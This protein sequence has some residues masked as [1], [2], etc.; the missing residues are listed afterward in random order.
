LNRRTIL[1][2]SGVLLVQSVLVASVFTPQP[3]SGG[4]NAGYISLAHSLL[5]RGAYLEL[6]DPDEPPHTK[7]PPVFAA[8]L[9]LAVLV[10]AKSWA[11]LKL[12]PAFSTVL[13]VAFSF[14]WAR[15]RHGPAL[16]VAVAVLVEISSS[17][18]YYSQWI[19]SD[20]AF[21]AVTVAALWF[22]HR[23]SP[24]SLGGEEREGRTSYLLMGM[25]LVVLAYFTR[26]AGLPLAVATILWLAIGKRWKLLAGFA[27]GFGVP[28]ALWW[29]RG[30]VL[31]GSEYVSEFWLIDPY[32]PHLGS[33]GFAELLDR[34]A[35]N[36][37]AYVTRIIPGGVVGDRVPALPPLGL[38][39]A[40][41]TLVGWLRVLRKE[42]GVAELF[43]PLYAGLILLWPQAWS[44]DR[45][46]LP[47]LPLIFFYSGTALIWLLSAVPER[48]RRV[49]L[50]VL[51]L[52]LVVPAGLFWSDLAR[53]A[54]SCRQSTRAGNAMECLS[55]AQAEYLA[56][57]EWSGENLP[58]GATVTTRKPRFFFLMSGK[59]SL[60]IP[61][62]R[63]P[64]ALLDR[65]RTRGSRYVSVDFLDGLSGYYLYPVL[66][67]NLS[68]FCGM[69]QIG[70]TGQMGTQMLGLLGGS[71]DTEAEASQTLP[72]CPAE[73]YG[74]P[75]EARGVEESWAIPLLVGEG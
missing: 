8:L 17:V 5:E 50:S 4:D 1:I 43:F 74:T 49:L 32:Q 33:V 68:A 55:P 37:G 2:L 69:I 7:Y 54:G 39:L 24:S 65:I 51:I 62:E 40:L 21:L 36:L 61:L 75:R 44:G 27:I 60:S 48:G 28:A 23:G 56:L 67:E 34:F 46:S 16:G 13:A 41:L 30:K 25:T 9:G 10:G 19:L 53:E 72:R 64:Q 59:K 6:W 11:A 66:M 3:H 52:V 22:L 45:F 47:L 58:S 42:L 31:G 15:D 14:L 73:M 70:P 29:L 57:A 18:V 71:P 35:G 12:V 38:G 20:P 63:D 26:S